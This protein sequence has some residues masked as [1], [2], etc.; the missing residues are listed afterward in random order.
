[1]RIEIYRVLRGKDAEAML[2]EGPGRRAV[3]PGPNQQPLAVSRRGRATLLAHPNVVFE[4]AVQ[5][6]VVPTA[7]VAGGHL[8]LAVAPVG[9]D[10]LPVLLVAGGGGPVEL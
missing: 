6:E 3:A 5:E 4:R 2:G 8:D 10:G 1:M 7:N 9:R